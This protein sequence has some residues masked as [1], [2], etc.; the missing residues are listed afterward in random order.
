MDLASAPAWCFG[1]K[2]LT[3]KSLCFRYCNFVKVFEVYLKCFRL[4]SLKNLIFSTINMCVEKCEQRKIVRL[5]LDLEL[6]F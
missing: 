1:L 6:E 3:L 2:Q 5:S 4:N